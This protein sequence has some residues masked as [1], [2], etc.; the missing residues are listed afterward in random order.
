MLIKSL[1]ENKEEKEKE[2]PSFCLRGMEAACCGAQGARLPATIKIH[3]S[4]RASCVWA[5]K[6]QTLSQRGEEALNFSGLFMC[7]Q[8]HYLWWP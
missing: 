5:E 2:P 3:C 6:R 8:H 1:M 7:S 4:H